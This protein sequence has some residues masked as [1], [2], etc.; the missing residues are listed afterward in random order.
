MIL[1]NFDEELII[2]KRLNDNDIRK[3]NMYVDN[4]EHKNVKKLRC[5]IKE[6]FGRYGKQ[7]VIFTIDYIFTNEELKALGVVEFDE[8]EIV[9]CTIDIRDEIFCEMEEEIKMLIYDEWI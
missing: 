2:Y 9:E 4:Y 5:S 6:A 8:D 1:E 3:I 7:E